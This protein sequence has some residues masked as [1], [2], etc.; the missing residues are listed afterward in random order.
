MNLLTQSDYDKAKKELKQLIWKRDNLHGSDSFTWHMKM[1]CDLFSKIL[2]AYRRK[3]GIYEVGD[4]IID[5]LI[6]NKVIKCHDG[7]LRELKFF[8]S[9]IRHA[10]DEEIEKGCRV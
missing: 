6:G 10:T 7:Y 3:N 1:Q 4:W 5:P 8:D 2:L 9:V